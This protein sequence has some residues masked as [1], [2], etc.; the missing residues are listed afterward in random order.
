MAQT[1]NLISAKSN[2]YSTILK[3][4]IDGEERI[5]I[6]KQSET[7]RLMPIRDGVQVKSIN[8]FG[9]AYF[10]EQTP[11]EAKKKDV[12]LPTISSIDVMQ[13]GDNLILLNSLTNNN[14]L[15]AGRL[16]GLSGRYYTDYNDFIYA[17]LN[18]A[19]IYPE[20]PDGDN[21]KILKYLNENLWNSENE[22]GE[23]G[24]ALEREKTGYE[25]FKS[26]SGYD[27]NVN[28][29]LV[30]PNNLE[31]PTNSFMELSNGALWKDDNIP[32]YTN[33]TRLQN[34]LSPLC[35][36]ELEHAGNILTDRVSMWRNY[37]HFNKT[38]GNI[39]ASYTLDLPAF[40]KKSSK[41]WEKPTINLNYTNNI[42]YG[43]LNPTDTGYTFSVGVSRFVP[44]IN[45]PLFYVKS[46]ISLN[47]ENQI[48]A[49]VI[50]FASLPQQPVVVYD[51]KSATP[52][53]EFKNNWGS[54]LEN[55]KYKFSEYNNVV[56]STF[57]ADNI[58]EESIISLD[59]AKIDLLNSQIEINDT[60]N[61][62]EG[63][64]IGN[65]FDVKVG[66][67]LKYSTMSTYIDLP[68]K[69]SKTYNV[70]N[71]TRNEIEIN[72]SDI[73]EQASTAHSFIIYWES[74]YNVSNLSLT[75]TA[76]AT[77]DY[78][79]IYPIE[80]SFTIT[81]NI[82]NRQATITLPNDYT[83]EDLL[84]DKNATA[85]LKF[86]FGTSTA[87]FAYTV[88]DGFTINTAIGGFDDISI[89]PTNSTSLTIN[90]GA[91]DERFNYNT[92]ILNFECTA[93]VH[94]LENITRCGK[95]IITAYSNSDNVI[96]IYA[97]EQLTKTIQLSDGE[98]T[99]IFLSNPSELLLIPQSNAG[100]VYANIT[101]SSYI[102]DFYNHPLLQSF[103]DNDWS[104]VCL[105]SNKEEIHNNDPDHYTEKDASQI[106]FEKTF[107]ITDGT[108][109]ILMP[110][111]ANYEELQTKYI[112]IKLDAN[113]ILNTT[114]SPDTPDDHFIKLFG[115][116]FILSFNKDLVRAIAPSNIGRNCNSEESPNAGIFI[117]PNLNGMSNILGCT[118]VCDGFNR[119][120]DA[121]LDI[122]NISASSINKYNIYGG[123]Y[124][125]TRWKDRILPGN[126]YHIKGSIT[127][128]ISSSN[129]TDNV[130]LVFAINNTKW[131][132]ANNKEV[133]T[134]IKGYEYGNLL[135]M[136]QTT[137]T[138]DG[139]IDTT[140]LIQDET[141]GVECSFVL[142]NNTSSKKYNMSLANTNILVEPVYSNN[143]Q[144]GNSLNYQ[145]NVEF[146]KI[147]LYDYYATAT[148]SSYYDFDSLFEN[149]EEF[150]NICIDKNQCTHLITRF[151]EI[152]DPNLNNVNIE[153]HADQFGTKI[154][155][156]YDSQVHCNI[157][158]MKAIANNYNDYLQQDIEK[159]TINITE[160]VD[161]NYFFGGFYIFG[162]VIRLVK[163]QQYEIGLD[164]D[165]KTSITLRI[166]FGS[167]LSNNP[168]KMTLT[169]FINGQ[170]YDEREYDSTSE[171]Y[172][173]FKEQFNNN[174]TTTPATQLYFGTSPAKIDYIKF[175]NYPLT[176]QNIEKLQSLYSTNQS[177]DK[178][179]TTI[180]NGVY[181]VNENS[182]GMISKAYMNESV[183]SLPAVIEK[184][185]SDITTTGNHIVNVDF[186]VVNITTGLID[187]EYDYASAAE[188]TLN[189]K[190]YL[191][192]DY[193]FIDNIAGLYK[194]NQSGDR[195]S[196]LYS[197]RIKNS[198][199]SI[200]EF[201]KYTP[202]WYMK[203]I[204]NTQMKS[205]L[206]AVINTLT[207]KIQPIN[208][209]LFKVIYDD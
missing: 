159:T 81:A 56:K 180:I 77:P 85:K 7:F 114:T 206:N 84:L 57:N 16:T 156:S 155:I 100:L 11:N 45:D 194:V 178:Y 117:R 49:N 3:L 132:I 40:A 168:Y 44:N 169:S 48:L 27:I 185:E 145:S 23:Y 30:N 75:Y 94:P 170:Q 138:V 129:V 17:K 33:Y 165:L 25:T 80:Q 207:K 196:N 173:Y 18:S 112:R 125:N 2:D 68:I 106:E 204:L 139:Y 105:N 184:N 134:N 130:S 29:N 90:S 142:V 150:K 28:P 128:N 153:L 199:L 13:Y 42:I 181:V 61:H 119:P 205:S 12:I 149:G 70:A 167:V 83:V 52:K 10:T 32:L 31:S 186:A 208:T 151:D 78:S 202:E 131:I 69:T 144:I 111:Y 86:T 35:N 154:P 140:D 58:T 120:Q 104:V 162:D 166:K 143:F 175:W 209:Q 141:L 183:D 47:E 89:M 53:F 60:P 79:I 158:E 67:N 92:E 126:K 192:K 152:D 198:G 118:I 102:E 4:V 82:V 101:Y 5:F 22:Y 108:V 55:G 163:P 88:I 20:V 157:A 54:T 116:Q 65:E 182:G 76:A 72:I 115:S 195:K 34:N 43:P 193:E 148:K 36:T 15:Y 121:V 64:A 110:N 6:G 41:S 203:D 107:N 50:E 135:S 136:T 127:A 188:G 62:G 51:G 21:D 124:G 37:I 66:T 8:S 179:K 172:K 39:W 133:I 91:F 97:G 73:A 46:L 24:Y 95:I 63:I 160:Y 176:N 1:I 74:P 14:V 98:E 174:W 123:G 200:N 19:A 187:I 197:I 189:K 171:T 87:Q 71:I 93:N 161:V 9:K 109:E 59:N 38:Q 147:H 99:T 164:S 177:I 26:L 113:S 103:Y 137:Y 146:T 191:L 201:A 122:S 190:L 96:T